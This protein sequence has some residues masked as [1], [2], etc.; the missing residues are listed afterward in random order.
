MKGGPGLRK[1]TT[2]MLKQVTQLFPEDEVTKRKFMDA[3]LLGDSREQAII[4]L[5]NQ[6]EIGAFP[7][8]R[9]MPCQP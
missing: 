3:L 4:V 7:R 6:P 2:L 1:P 8:E 9:R 5:D